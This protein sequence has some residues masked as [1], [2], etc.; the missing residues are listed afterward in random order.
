MQSTSERKK[1]KKHACEAYV[2]TW[3]SIYSV[4]SGIKGIFC[5]KKKSPFI[6][7]KYFHHKEG[8]RQMQEAW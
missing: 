5:G 2:A 6:L 4:K 7:L 1:K 3:K 8:G